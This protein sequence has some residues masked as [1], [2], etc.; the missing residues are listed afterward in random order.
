MHNSQSL[1]LLTDLYQIT[2]SAAYFKQ[3][4][5]NET[6]VF[7]LFF[8]KNPFKGNYAISCGLKTV[9]DYINNFKFDVSDIEYLKT[10]KGN[11]DKP[12]FQNDFLEYLSNLKFEG[13][14]DA[15]EEGRIVFPHEPMLRIKAPIIFGQLLETPLLN[16]LNFQTL[17]ATK[18]QRVCKAA[19]GDA[20][21][22]FGLRR[23]QGVDGALSA[24]YASMVGGAH[25]TSNVLAG[26][27]HG[28]DVKGT[29][30]HSWVMSYEEEV[31]AFEAY[32]DSMPNNCTF[33]VDTYNTKNGITHA[34]NTGKKLREKGHEM[35]GIR[36]DSGDLA[37]LSIIARQMLDD[38]GFPNT[39]IVA[40]NDLD[41]YRIMELKKAGA[42]IDIWGV[43]TKLVTAYDQPAL[44]GVY[45]L[46]AIQSAQGWK[47]KIKKSEDL[48]KVS[49]P[50]VLNI[51]RFFDQEKM[52]FDV[53]YN[54]EQGLGDKRYN[55]QDNQEA[56]ID[57]GLS[58]EDLLV[59]IFKAGKLVYKIPSIQETH[60]KRMKDLASLST[61]LSK[62]ETSPPFDV[63]LE[64]KVYQLKLDLLKKI[65]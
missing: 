20:V 9:I 41:E 19:Q 62:L 18:T 14:I 51:K 16:I 5:A 42:K 59:P 45:K 54:S 38:G 1:S 40:S 25:A 57:Q 61:K 27:I 17:I 60:Q 26:K 53:I 28:M 32:A 37:A 50:G 8:R 56:L 10:L 15:V 63:S 44:G 36:L 2:M 12:L 23:A 49:N 47:Y 7:H 30:A 31:E 34:I 48:I 65:N 3:G 4:R 64:G 6:A 13:D 33:L 22:E 39:K 24:A 11:D 35:V 21:L 29:H 52:C 58:S 46:G 55:L 43:G